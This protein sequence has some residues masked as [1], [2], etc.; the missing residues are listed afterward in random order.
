MEDKCKRKGCLREPKDESGLCTI[1]KPKPS[2]KVFGT[3]DKSDEDVQNEYRVTFS[4]SCEET[5]KVVAPN[6]DEAKSIAEDE[7]DYRGEIVADLNTDVDKLKTK[8]KEELIK[9]GELEPEVD[10]TQ[11]KGEKSA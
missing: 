3:S 5:V 7:R 2:D 4:Y 1:H 8:T 9:A 6:E 11:F 10:W